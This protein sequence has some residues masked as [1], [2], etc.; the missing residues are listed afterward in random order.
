M[1]VKVGDK[2]WNIHVDLAREE[3]EVTTLRRKLKDGSFKCF[4]Y[5]GEG[6]ENRP[7]EEEIEEFWSE[8]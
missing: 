5:R 3:E 6:S 8:E 2:V 1:E 4:L 7:T